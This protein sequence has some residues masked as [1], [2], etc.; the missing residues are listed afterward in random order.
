MH[1]VYFNLSQW[2]KP[3]KS[4]DIYICTYYNYNMPLEWSSEES[5]TDSRILYNNRMT[6]MPNEIHTFEY[7]YG[8]FTNIKLN[9]LCD[10]IGRMI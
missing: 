3:F 10:S 6:F 5:R 7:P 8:Y 4:I 1:V 9:K 2:I